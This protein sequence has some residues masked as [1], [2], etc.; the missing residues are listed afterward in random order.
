MLSSISADS[1]V[2]CVDTCS[3]LDILHE[4]MR[5]DVRENDRTAALELINIAEEHS[6][7]Y[8]CTAELVQKEYIDT[9]DSVEDRS[10]RAI[11]ELCNHVMKMERLSK[12]HGVGGG[13]DIGHWQEYV[14]KCREVADRWMRVGVVLAGSDSINE[15][16]LARVLSGR[17]PSR[18]GKESL[19]DCI[20]IETYLNSVREVRKV[21]F[22]GP[23][24]FMSSNTS[25][26][27]SEKNMSISDD[28]VDEFKALQLEY[29]SNMAAARNRLGL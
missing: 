28:L 19:K 4:P 1:R 7:L 14:E 12:I 8:V 17:S 22:S 21:G 5:N 20:I 29:V 26:F 27:A 2:L 10:K 24:V 16:A 23:V 15:R 13:V 9:V 25:D 6:K 3:I 11:H 18:R